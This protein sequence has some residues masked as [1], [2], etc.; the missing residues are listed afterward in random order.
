MSF[1]KFSCEKDKKKQRRKE[2][3]TDRQRESKRTTR[4]ENR[5]GDRLRPWPGVSE[6]P[7]SRGS[8]VSPQGVPYAN[9]SWSARED[10]GKL[11]GAALPIWMKGLGSLPLSSDVIPRGSQSKAASVLA[12]WLPEV[13]FSTPPP[14]LGLGSPGLLSPPRAAT[15]GC[16]AVPSPSWPWKNEGP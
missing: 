7:V 1:P 8:Q 13:V 6:V 9:P 10:S 14:R 4:Q 5:K 11:P 12:I 16:R 15:K 3:S 2:C